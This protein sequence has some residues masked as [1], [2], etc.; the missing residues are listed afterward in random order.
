MSR[1]K[2]DRIYMYGIMIVVNEVMLMARRY[3]YP[4]YEENEDDILSLLILQDVFPTLPEKEKVVLGLRLQGFTQGAIS[5]LL[6]ISRTSIGSLEKKAVQTI[7]SSI[8][9][10]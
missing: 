3:P 1:S 4:T 7:S 2:F 8:T 9:Q 10:E 5:R 6:N